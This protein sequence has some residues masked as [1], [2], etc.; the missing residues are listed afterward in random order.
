MFIFIYI[1]GFGFYYFRKIK[2]K[3]DYKVNK[4]EDQKNADSVRVIM[5]RVE[6][7]FSGKEDVEVKRLA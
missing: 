1:S 6:V 7:V 2:L 4:I 3:Y 5:S